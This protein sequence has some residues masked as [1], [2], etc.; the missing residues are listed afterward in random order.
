M[1]VLKVIEGW[2]FPIGIDGATGKIMSVCDNEAI[3][4]SVNMILQTQVQEREIF[5]DYGSNLRSFM[6]DV[7]DP[8]YVS[9]FKR[10]V[11]QSI[12]NCEPHVNEISVEVRAEGGST[13]KIVSEIEYSTDI[14]PEIEKIYKTLNINGENE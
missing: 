9:S 1:L 12:S 10:S 6:F 13:S 8:N 5:G 4:Q 7:I 14:Y 2:R 11:E 3:K